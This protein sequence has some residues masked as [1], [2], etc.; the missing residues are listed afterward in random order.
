LLRISAFGARVA[1]ALEYRFEVDVCW[2]PDVDAEPLF[3]HLWRERER[4]PTRLIGKG[5]PAVPDDLIFAADDTDDDALHTFAA[6]TDYGKEG[7]GAG[8]SNEDTKAEA[9]AARG[10]LSRRLWC[11]LLSRAGTPSPPFPP[12]FFDAFAP[13]SDPCPLPRPPTHVQ[14]SPRTTS[15]KKRPKTTSTSWWPSSWAGATR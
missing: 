1:A 12:S 2:L 3:D 4:H 9:G 14:G 13:R 7:A 8:G 6:E 10:T 15:G 5:F 11:Y